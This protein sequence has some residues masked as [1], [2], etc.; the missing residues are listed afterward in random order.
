MMS[1]DLQMILSCGTSHP[2]DAKGDMM[3]ATAR[4]VSLCVSADLRHSAA[5][6]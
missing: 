5:R 4:Q 3:T 1:N 6:L 2:C